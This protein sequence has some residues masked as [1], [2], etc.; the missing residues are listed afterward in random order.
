MWLYKGEE[1]TED[2]IGNSFGFVYLI[3]NLLNG[4][5]YLGKKLFTKASRKQTKGKIKKIRVTSDWKNYWSSSDTLKE[6][7][8][9]LGVI[10]RNK[11]F[12]YLSRSRFSI[13]EGSNFFSIFCQDCLSNGVKMFYDKASKVKN[14]LLP[15]K[16]FLEIDFQNLSN[17]LKI[18]EKNIN[19]KTVLKKHFFNKK[20]F[21]TNYKSYFNKF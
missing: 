18:I 1:F 4:R 13:N 10:S 11:L 8:K 19:V 14:D 7:V 5:K 9:N 2:L 15:K 17:S 16:Y 12:Y 6:D 20:E 21:L 3:T